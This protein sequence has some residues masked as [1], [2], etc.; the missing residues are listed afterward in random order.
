MV[1]RQDLRRAAVLCLSQHEGS[2]VELIQPVSEL[3]NCLVI[4]ILASCT[5]LVFMALDFTALLEL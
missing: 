2:I 4:F 1:R 3:G 5:D